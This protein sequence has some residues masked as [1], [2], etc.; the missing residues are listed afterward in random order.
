MTIDDKSLD[1]LASHLKEQ[2]RMQFLKSVGNKNVKGAT[3]FGLIETKDEAI[4]NEIAKRQIDADVK[5]SVIQLRLYQNS[6][7]R[8]EVIAND[9][10]E[11]YKLPFS[12]SLG[13]AFYNGWEIFLNLILA[14]AHLWMFIIAGTLAWLAIKYYYGKERKFIKPT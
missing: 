13:N 9:S 4:E 11:E 10:I 8:R 1:Y 5:Y 12:K 3:S 14:L 2:N 6:L 7:V